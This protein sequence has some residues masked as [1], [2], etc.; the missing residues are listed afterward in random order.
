MSKSTTEIPELYEETWYEEGYFILLVFLVHNIFR[1]I[2]YR[3]CSTN[4]LYE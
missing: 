4:F 3:V 2:F 1:K